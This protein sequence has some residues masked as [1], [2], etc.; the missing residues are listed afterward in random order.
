MSTTFDFSNGRGY[1]DI[2]NT[3]RAVPDRVSNNR[4]GEKLY[5]LMNAQICIKRLEDAFFW[6]RQ[7][8]LAYLEKELAFYLSGSRE[9]K[10]AV[11]CSK[12][13]EKC[14]DDGQTINSNYGAML[15]HDCNAEGFTQF[16]YALQALTNNLHSKKAVMVLHGPEHGYISN[17]NPCTMFIHFY[18]TDH[19]R[20]S[21]GTVTTE[22]HELHMRVVMRSNDIWFGATYDV[23]FFCIVWEVMHRRLAETYSTPIKRGVYT[24]QALNLHF[25]ERDEKKWLECQ[26][27]NKSSSREALEQYSS[28]IHKYVGK[29]AALSSRHT[30]THTDFMEEAWVASQRSQ[31]LKKKCGCVIVHKDRGIVGAG[32][33]GRAYG[34]AC[35][36]C[37]RDAG[38]VFHGDSCWSVHAEMRAVNEATQ[39][40]HAISIDPSKTEAFFNNCTAYVTHGPCDACLKLLDLVG[41][42]TVYYAEPYKTNYGHWPRMSVMPLQRPE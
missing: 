13:W 40:A 31:C 5:E 34:D 37:A 27:L 19:D 7:P 9:L 18:V 17:D 20:E 15:F 24:H 32:Y 16:E 6:Q 11:V 8:S 23:P 42:R 1:S 14:S 29:F 39:K 22:W 25:Y 26:N 12:F 28:I 3:L 21:E 30:K 2:V 10:D 41:V 33:G 36:T 4:K 38:E 35:T